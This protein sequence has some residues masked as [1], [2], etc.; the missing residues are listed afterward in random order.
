[1]TNNHLKI[2]N[3]KSKT[4]IDNI[5]KLFFN[6][7]A[8]LT[9]ILLIGFVILS[10]ASIYFLLRSTR[11]EKQLESE[12]EFVSKVPG[13]VKPIASFISDCIKGS[14][15]PALELIGAQAGNIFLGD[16]TVKTEYG[17]LSYGYLN[18]KNLLPTIQ[19]IATQLGL[20]MNSAIDACANLSRFEQQ[21]YVFEKG[22]INTQVDITG[23]NIIFNV[24]Y[25]LKATKGNSVHEIK[26]FRQVVKVGLYNII[27]YSNSIIEK[28]V[29]DPYN[30]ESTYLASLPYNITVIPIGDNNIVYFISDPNSVL[31]N[32]QYTFV[33]VAKYLQNK[34]PVMDVNRTYTMIDSQNFFLQIPASDAENDNL[35]FSDD[36]ALFDIDTKEIGGSTYGLINVTPEIPGIYNVTLKVKDSFGNDYK[37]KVSFV[38]KEKVR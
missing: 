6:R 38:V 26:D 19:A 27:G 3:K 1:M 23:N 31:N 29:K 33:F 8:Q 28:I 24:E 11:V 15:V 5:S 18:T 10:T 2:N 34:A 14:S 37:R 21:G 32:R 7:R 36:T 22:K 4:A 35:T 30:I 13:E 9:A 25:P 20:Y 12:V 17:E 16:D